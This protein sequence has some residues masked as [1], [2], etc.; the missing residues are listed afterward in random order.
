MQR[1]KLR[2]NIGINHCNLHNLS[3]QHKY[4]AHVVKLQSWKSGFDCLSICG[5]GG[6]FRVM[7]VFRFNLNGKLRFMVINVCNVL[8]TFLKPVKHLN[9][10]FGDQVQEIW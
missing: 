10:I 6:G 1:S 9:L 2:Y 7:F 5:I 3:L 8:F 4:C